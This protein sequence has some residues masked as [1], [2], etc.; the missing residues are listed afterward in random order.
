MTGLHLKGSSRTTVFVST[1][2][3]ERRTCLVKPS[4]QLRELGDEDTNVFHM[5]SFIGTQRV[6]KE[7][8]SIA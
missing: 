6:L 5:A 8:C 4:S 7:N 3:E 2:P 1:V